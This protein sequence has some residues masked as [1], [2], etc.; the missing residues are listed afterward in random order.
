MPDVRGKLGGL[1]RLDALLREGDRKLVTQIDGLNWIL[2]TSDVIDFRIL[3]TAGHDVEVRSRMIRMAT[4][5]GGVFWDVGANIGSITLP[6]VHAHPQWEAYCFEPSPPVASRLVENLAT[7]PELASRVHVLTFALAS[8]CGAARFYPS[9]EQDNSGLGSLTE[10]KLR[11]PG[12]LTV[13]VCT[14]DEL[15]RSEE[16]PAPDLIKI[17]VEGYEAD[18]IQGLSE[19]LTSEQ[20]RHVN[21]LVEHD[22]EWLQAREKPLDAVSQLLRRLGFDLELLS[23][24][25]IHRSFELGHLKER[26]TIIAR[27][28]DG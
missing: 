1:R 16:V 13:P 22:P 5:V 28:R 12:S 24:D 18:V 20:S 19:T 2:R 6:F 4:D 23:T 9:Y 26:H 21:L 15:V 7:N 17:D 10:S 27:R 3:Y 25:G 11:S 14:G 8:F